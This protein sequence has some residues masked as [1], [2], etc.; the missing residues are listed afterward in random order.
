MENTIAIVS[1]VASSIVALVAGLGPLLFQWAK[2]RTEQHDLRKQAL[3]APMLR[4]LEAIAVVQALDT[5]GA[6]DTGQ[7]ARVYAEVLASYYA[8]ENVTR[9]RLNATETAGFETLRD[10]INNFPQTRG[11]DPTFDVLHHFGAEGPKISAEVFAITESADL[12]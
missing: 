7:V 4:L 5:E 3:R 8:W 11:S 10:A 1:V 12:R 2:W 9:P 6:V